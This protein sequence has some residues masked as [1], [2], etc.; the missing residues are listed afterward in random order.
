[1]SRELLEEYGLELVYY[2]SVIAGVLVRLTDK[3]ANSRLTALLDRMSHLL[4]D[5]KRRLTL[6]QK[7]QVSEPEPC[8]CHNRV[9][10]HYTPYTLPLV[11][12][13]GNL[14]HKLLVADFQGACCYFPCFVFL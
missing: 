5:V 6:L 7:T 12:L 3:G 13:V 1:M 8:A 4:L 2:Q 11:S 10:R 9:Y 14:L